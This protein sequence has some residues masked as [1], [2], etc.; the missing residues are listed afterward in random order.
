MNAIKSLFVRKRASDVD[1]TVGSI[2]RHIISFAI[3]LFIGN[4]FQM[5]YNMV[6]T[7]VV[8]NFVND[9]AFSAVGTTGSVTNL[10]IGFFSGFATGSGVVISQYFGAGNKARVKDTVHTAVAFTLVLSVL[11]TVIGLLLVPVFLMMLGMPSN[12]EAEA[13]IYLTVWFSGISGLM[14]YNMSAAIMRAVGDSRR[15]F[16]YLMVSALTNVVLDLV[17]VL[18]FDMGVA[19]VS[20]A[21]VIAQ[22]ASAIL[23]VINLLRTN[24]AVRVTPKDIRFDL[25]LLARIAKISFPTAMQMAITSFSN[26]FIHSYIN[27]FGEYAMGGYTAYSKLDHVVVLPMQSI[28]L[29]V[30]TFVGQNVGKGE[31][32]RAAKGANVAFMLS[33]MGTLILMTPIM[34]FSDFFASIFNPNPEI[35]EYASLLIITMTPFYLFWTVNQTYAGALRGAGKTLPVMMIMLFSFVVFRQ[36]YLYILTNFIV[37]DLVWVAACFPMGWIIAAT[38]T[39]IYYKLVG[40]KPKE[41]AADKGERKAT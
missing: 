28:G 36:I 9:A 32:K 26:I 38:L 41:P 22:F 37:N 25:P 20:L 13:N 1:M 21:T 5:L 39:F 33:V 3:P 19:G 4:L 35:I 16:I 18:V 30:S 27:A 2:P 24:S 29:A 31:L 17:F 6:D 14:I 7:W 12:V 34:L 10:M 15:P 23:C 8:G 11:F 40:L